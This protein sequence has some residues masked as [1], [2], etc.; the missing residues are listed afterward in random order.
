MYN[1][2]MYGGS[3][4]PLHLGHV[5][6]I[7]EAANQCRK[8]YIVLAVGNNRNEIDK[9][10]RY[11]WLY[12]LTK[13]IV[14]VKI[15]FIED[16]ADTKEEYTEDLWEEDSIKIKNAIGENID[17]VFLGDDYKDKDSFYTRHYKDSELIFIERN[18]ISSSKIRENVYKYW[19]YLPNIVKPYYT[20]KV[21]LL[22]SESTGKSTL[23]INLANYYNTNYIEEAGREL[24]EKSVTDL[25]MLSEDF[26]EILLTHKLNEIKAIEYS[27]KILFIDTDAV[28][29][30][31]YMHFLEDEN[32][33][34][35]E[36]LA[37]A[38]IHINKYDLI[39][40]LEPDV[41]F[42]DDGDRSEVIKNDRIKY[43]NKIKDIL[44]GLNIKY[45][46]INGNYQERFKKSISIIDALF[47]NI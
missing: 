3:F 28:I 33:I 10:V 41:D 5:R 42:I 7:I 6:C 17:A 23:T 20:K 22:G 12:Q 26:T 43:S 2:G 27:S 40:F 1:V 16:N 32:I 44:N 47:C 39:L 9:K 36:R 37:K 15:I 46:S 35:N 24:S 4:N 11:R 14:N 30:N 8:L 25:L 45:Y 29:T 31:F 18:E 19:D 38:I 21:L 34:D 13:H